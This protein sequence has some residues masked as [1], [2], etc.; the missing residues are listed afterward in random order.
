MFEAKQNFDWWQN[1]GIAKI[2]LIFL[3]EKQNNHY[4]WLINI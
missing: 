2:K 1:E 4:K 3:A